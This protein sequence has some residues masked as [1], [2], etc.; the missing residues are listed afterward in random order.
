VEWAHVNGKR[1][2]G[3]DVTFFVEG[4]GK[5]MTKTT[6][7]DVPDDQFAGF[8]GKAIDTVESVDTTGGR[9]AVRVVVQD[10][11]TGAAGSLTIPLRQR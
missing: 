7:V 4:S 8:Q 1:S 9:E 6:K 2:G 10:R 5:F 3:I 11:T